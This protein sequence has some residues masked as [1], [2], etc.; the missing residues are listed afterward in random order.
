[1]RAHE[2]RIVAWF[3]FKMQAAQCFTC[4]D[5][6]AFSLIERMLPDRE[7]TLLKYSTRIRILR[8]A[9]ARGSS[10]R[11]NVNSW[12]GNH[13][14]HLVTKTWLPDALLRGRPW[15]GFVVMVARQFATQAWFGKFMQMNQRQRK[16]DEHDGR[17]RR[18][19]RALRHSKAGWERCTSPRSSR[20]RVG[21]GRCWRFH[22]EDEIEDT[23]SISQ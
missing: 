22:A 9:R 13:H 19:L 2:W 1:M 8:Y 6:N 16:S 15:L 23:M 3:L 7:F 21:K 11:D 17:R 14:T 20:S 10:G 18:W 12:S 5:R 4:N